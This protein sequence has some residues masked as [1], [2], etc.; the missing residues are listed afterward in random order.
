[1]LSFCH[2]SLA[3]EG[4][5]VLD[6]SVYFRHYNRFGVN[7]YCP[8]VLKTE[9]EQVLSKNGFDRL[10]RD[11]ERFLQQKGQDPSKV[12]WTEHVF[13]PMFANFAP[14]PA[15]PPP[16]DWVSGSFDDSGWVLRRRP[17]QGTSP[18]DITR[19][20]L[21]QFDESMDLGL[22]HSYYRAR[23]V[24]EDPSTADLTFSATY[25]GGLR[26]LI[27]GQE[28]ARGHLP[29]GE[30]DA[31]ACGEDYPQQ[32]YAAEGIALRDRTIG[33]VRIPAKLL[34]AAV[35]VLAIEVHASNFHPIVLKNERQ[36]NW[37]G[38]MRPWPH[39]QLC[40]LEVRSSSQALRS[41]TTRPGGL[42]VWVA[43]VNRQMR[44]DDFLPPGESAGT[45][46][47]VGARNGTYS[48]QI[49]VGTD[50]SVSGLS[51]TPGLLR[52]IAGQ[53]TLP[54]SA[55]TVSGV[56]P[57]PADQWT[58]KYLGDERGLNA[59]F[60]DSRTL[61]T[62][63]AMEGQSG[64]WIFDQIT[65]RPAGTIPANASR[66]IWLSL[67]IPSG[68]TAGQYRGVV[69]VATRETPAVEI[70]VELTVV[71][72][73][74]P[75]PRDFQTLVGC[76]ENP[77]GVARQYGVAAWSDDHFRLIAASLA[78]L[79]RIGNKWVNLP[80]LVNTEYGNREDSM[81][82]WTRT[83]D[84]AWAFDYAI[85]DQYLDL[86]L[87]H[88]GPPRVI[89]AVVMHGMKSAA[90]LPTPGQVR[91][92]DE[93]SGKM[94]LMDMDCTA[95]A[96]E[97]VAAWQAFARSLLA[98]MK[99]RGLDKAVYWGHPLESE[100]DPQLQKVLAEATPDVFWI[101]GP[102]EM[103]S[104]GT[105]AKNENVYKL[106]ETIRYWGKWP[107]FRMDQGWRSPR[108][109]V[110]NPRVG[111]TVFGM[112]TTSLPLAYRIMPDHALAFGRSG[113]T[114][115]GADEWAGVHY[116]GCVV[117]KWETGVPVLFMLWPGKE[118]AQSS[119]R[120]EA[121][122]EGLQETEVRIFLEQAIERGN[123]PADLAA[124][125]KKALADNLQET[126]FFQGNSMI[127]AFEEYYFGWQERSARLYGAAADAAKTLR[128]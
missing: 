66:P 41:A 67:R 127:R 77:Y 33:P 14:T 111:G 113:F 54:G 68:A 71:D 109:H 108:L 25:H 83:K 128:N 69:K 39:A 99:D 86:V 48:A 50:K 70:P 116:D 103:M 12:D 32:A 80:V 2:C 72:W 21:G 58:L 64:P 13:Q 35:N 126:M 101:A 95:N 51:V 20:N 62:F 65:S 93:K 78:Q 102:H 7:R 105:Y 8:V 104:N 81:I 73:A 19:P 55:V 17:F 94:A 82:R 114:R 88:C 59:A 107:T 22:L 63:A 49:M 45:I 98:H 76:E 91:F 115:V 42:Q 24:I 61:D 16:Q 37:G 106:V 38:P 118:G 123:L 97:S 53:E 112:H 44:S 60:P 85:L 43:D 23:L 57:F 30:L 31:D 119:V 5:V 27:N 9:G 90:Q 84:G 89:N 79:G 1:V 28:I 34:R 56:L 100:A 46:R 117:A 92:M 96:P 47:I 29:A 121:L 120:F 10:K 40:K 18:R 122:L 74:L 75:S 15:G 3:A 6:A 36:P 110:L 11:T 124:R 125:V 26:V 52:Q 87:K 4:S